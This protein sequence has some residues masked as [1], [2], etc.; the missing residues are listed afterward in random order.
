MNQNMFGTKKL[1]G[2]AAVLFG[3]QS[4]PYGE[5][6]ARRWGIRIFPIKKEHAFFCRSQITSKQVFESYSFLWQWPSRSLRK[7]SFLLGTEDVWLGLLGGGIGARMNS[8]FYS[9]NLSACCFTFSKKPSS[10]QLNSTLL[11][12]IHWIRTSALNGSFTGGIKPTPST[13]CLPLMSFLIRWFWNFDCF[14]WDY[15]DF[16]MQLVNVFSSS[17]TINII[18]NNRLLSLGPLRC[19]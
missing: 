5:G 14:T 16:K 17:R 11:D 2:F 6:G 18:F 12:L 15:Y 4:Q 8:S 7:L 13:D 10:G 19:S 1:L 3:S 9:E